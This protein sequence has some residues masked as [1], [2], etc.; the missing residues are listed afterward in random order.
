MKKQ[1][2]GLLIVALAGCASHPIPRPDLLTFLEAE[3]V[4]RKDVEAHLGPPSAAF[5]R[6]GVLTYRLSEP[7][8]GYFV[9]PP[10]K[11]NTNLDWRGVNYD[12]VLAFDEAGILSAH[13]LIA[14]HPKETPK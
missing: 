4:T 14:I 3:H 5:D 8:E 13:N 9:A 7:K 11:H 2:G 6:D 1:I 10:M 12:L